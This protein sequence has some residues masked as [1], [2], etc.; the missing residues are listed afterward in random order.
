MKER[1][2]DIKHIFFIKKN[3]KLTAIRRKKEPRQ[4]YGK[5]AIRKKD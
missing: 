5:F 2:S 3:T 4:E 1:E